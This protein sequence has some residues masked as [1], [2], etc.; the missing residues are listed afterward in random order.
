VK[1]T[2][3]ALPFVHTGPT[4]LRTHMRSCTPLSA[5]ANYA[6][7]RAHI[8]VLTSACS[9]AHVSVLSAPPVSLSRAATSKAIACSAMSNCSRS[10]LACSCTAPISISYLR[11]NRKKKETSRRQDEPETKRRAKPSKTRSVH[12]NRV[13]GMRSSSCPSC[14]GALTYH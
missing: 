12:A 14:R 8:I 5:S 9:L 13:T 1:E 2:I 6:H 7:C 11:N 10:F 3:H 4:Q